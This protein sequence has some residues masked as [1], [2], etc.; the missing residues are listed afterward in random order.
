[1]CVHAE[2]PPGGRDQSHGSGGHAGG[3]Y[4]SRL[5]MLEDLDPKAT[6]SLFVGN[7]PKHINVYD[8]RDAFIRYGTVLVSRNGKIEGYTVQTCRLDC[9]DIMHSYN[10]KYI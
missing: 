6:R 7:I 3:E 2:F 5:S 8:L 10:E 9:L 1:M 4:G